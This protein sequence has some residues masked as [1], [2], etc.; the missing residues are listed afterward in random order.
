MGNPSSEPKSKLSRCYYCEKRKPLDEIHKSSSKCDCNGCNG[1]E[2]LLEKYFLICDQCYEAI[3]QFTPSGNEVI[4]KFIRETCD[5]THRKME[6]V[7]HSEFKDLEFIAEGGFSKIYKATWIDGPITHWNNEKQK[8]Y[9]RP[10]KIVALKELN[11]SNNIHSEELNE[12]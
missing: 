6:F 2:D 4:D 9:R 11:N 12:V 7:H 1:R 3:S 8:Y 5:K 10:N